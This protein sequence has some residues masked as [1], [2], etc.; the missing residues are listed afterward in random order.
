MT[1]PTPSPTFTF[2]SRDAILRRDILGFGWAGIGLLVYGALLGI[3]GYLYL[4][5]VSDSIVARVGGGILV[6]SSLAC[7]I[8]AIRLFREM[9]I[10]WAKLKGYL[11]L[12]PTNGIRPESIRFSLS[13][14][15][16]TGITGCL[17]IY[18]ITWLAQPTGHIYLK[19]VIIT[20]LSLILIACVMVAT[21]PLASLR[22]RILLLK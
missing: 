11:E 8:I 14:L 4:A 6:L 1:T 3:L 20:C 18:G 12:Y 7:L 21:N 9:I 17:V 13:S 19:V 2:P 16:F 15:L 5:I 10:C 22:D